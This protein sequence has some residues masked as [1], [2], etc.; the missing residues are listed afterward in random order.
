MKKQSNPEWWQV[1]I[2]EYLTNGN[3]ATRAY[4]ECHAV[5]TTTAEVESCRLLRNPK[6][7]KL[8]DS[9]IEALNQKQSMTREEWIK[10]LTEVGKVKTGING[11]TKVKALEL[12]GKSLGYVTEK[13]EV[14]GNVTIVF[15]SAY[16]QNSQKGKEPIQPETLPDNG[17]QQP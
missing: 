11:A 9:A 4:L 6:F 15:E 12:L 5:K 14:G 13:M 10:T 2:T 1:F 16:E 8:M 3:N 7:K 17:P